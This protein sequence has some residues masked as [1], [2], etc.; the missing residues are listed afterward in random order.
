MSSK[1]GARDLMAATAGT[2]RREGRAMLAAAPW[3]LAVFTLTLPFALLVY[4][5]NQ[6]RDLL[7]VALAL[8]NL[9]ALSRMTF[10]WHRVVVLR[11]AGEAGGAGNIGD[12]G[13]VRG[14]TAEAKH[15]L[16]LSALAI[17][18]AVL[19]RATGDIPFVLYMMLDGP[20]NAVF[21]G[22]VI[23]AIALVWVPVLYLLAAVGT[24]LPRAVATGEY[25]F[26]SMRAAMR[27]PRWPVMLTLF[28]LI[29]VATFAYGYLFPLTYFVREAELAKGV[30]TI[31]LSVVMTFVLM[32]ML[33]VAY[34][35]SAQ[36]A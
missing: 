12:I 17:G 18:T 3:S 15:L 8:V 23:A 33:A 24:S 1:L 13:D 29:V 16:L 14:G 21:F 7:W 28:L 31:L 10:A 19:M 5:L 30:F 36:D 6:A 20:A 22:S 34:R 26:R 9:I 25:G 4:R 35:D 11:G 27:Y 2:I 32:T